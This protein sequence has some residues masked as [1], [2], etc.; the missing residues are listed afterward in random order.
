MMDPRQAPHRAGGRPATPPPAS[1]TDGPS[2]SHTGETMIPEPSNAA[3]SS[4]GSSSPGSSSSGRTDSTPSSTSSAP[5]PSAGTPSGTAPWGVEPA[6]D[7]PDADADADAVASLDDL[8]ERTTFV[9][10]LLPG[11]D[12]RRTTTAELARLLRQRSVIAAVADGDDLG[13]PG[14]TVAILA[15][16][17]DGRV[18]LDAD[19]RPVPGQQVEHL[20]PGLAHLTG[21]RVVVDDTVVVAPD[22]T[23]SEP[24]ED[25]LAART[26]TTL[27]LWRAS[28]SSPMIVRAIAH[29]AGMPVEHATL[30]GWTVVALPAGTTVD[31]GALAAGAVGSGERPVVALTRAGETRSVSWHH[32]EKRREVT[33]ELVVGPPTEVVLRD[34][35]VGSVSAR[36]AAELGDGS[37][38]EVP[39]TTHLDEA[40]LARLRALPLDRATLLTEAAEALGLPAGLAET[41]ER[42]GAAARAAGE[43]PH[44]RAPVRWLGLPDAAVLEP[45]PS[46]GGMVARGLVDTVLEEPRGDG[47]YARFRRWLW[48]RPGTLVAVSV[49]EVLVG[50]GFA[51][52]ALAGGTL[53]GQGWLVWVAAALWLVDG[54]PDL[55]SGVALLKRRRR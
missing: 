4:P 48:H 22:G 18:L 11:E 21:C 30:D 6:A 42:A 54:L 35:A 23:E 13:T 39:T 51:A 25:A 28:V 44:G 37:M 33:V 19:G 55:A 1:H 27:V 9:L 29:G 43:E 52:W 45:D 38:R 8:P 26:A 12:G 14:A 10:S 17:D 5:D 32:R 20:V 36:L 2:P 16:T 50:L 15:T 53:L 3:P 40:T 31:A 49:A 47:R 41:V 46:A 24:D 7:A 34:G